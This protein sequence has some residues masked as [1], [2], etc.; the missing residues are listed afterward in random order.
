MAGSRLAGSG[1]RQVG[2]DLVVI[3]AAVLVLDD[4][5]GCGQV[6]DDRMGA[7]LG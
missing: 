6:S 5:P 7:A 3:A 2:L 4:V 1:K